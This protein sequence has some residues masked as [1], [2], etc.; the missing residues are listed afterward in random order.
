MKKARLYHLTRDPVTLL[1]G[2]G[3]ICGLGFAL[4]W[5]ITFA[6]WGRKASPLT[7]SPSSYTVSSVED[8][9]TQLERRLTLEQ[10]MPEAVLSEGPE[11]AMEVMMSAKEVRYHIDQQAKDAA[12][13]ALFLAHLDY[14]EKLEDG[15]LLPLTQALAQ[16]P[17]PRFANHLMASV[18]EAKGE[19]TQAML[20]YQAEAAHPEAKR[21]A[22]RAIDLAIQLEDAPVLRQL[23]QSHAATF[24]IL[25]AWDRCA[26]GMLIQDPGLQWEGAAAAVF[27]EVTWGRLLLTTL[28]SA[29]WFLVLMR[30]RDAAD[31]LPWW[32][33]P[34]ALLLGVA[35]IVPTVWFVQF[36][37]IRLGLK[38]GATGMEQLKY[39]VVGVGLREELA[40][41]LL[42]LPFLPW[43]LRK[44]SPGLAL[45]TGALV[46]LGFA[47]EENV[48]YFRQGLASEG[49]GRMLTANFM[50][51]AMTGITALAAYDLCRSK[52]V[53]M[54]DFITV[55]AVIVCV[56]GV[57]DWSFTGLPELSLLGSLDIISI[58]MLALL[59]K[60]F[61]ESVSN[62]LVPQRG[63]ISAICILVW[64]AC[65]MLALAFVSAA[66]LGTGG[67]GIGAVGL[68]ALGYIPLLVMHTRHLQGI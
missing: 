41:L 23:Y 32:W 16:T 24:H 19:W 21:A 38:E 68:G 8:L 31:R 2:A 25:R 53:R 30:Y 60:H 42:V 15:L 34:A 49:Y 51:L 18:M 5:L 14:S 52:F 59:A 37:E 47:F 63:N 62:T 43:L 33:P 45:L 29:I 66:L 6:G 4:A 55:F 7:I 40:K 11:V 46:G 58:V 17:P 9:V 35:S 3:I 57:Y 44:K 22:T 50:H 61:F 20:L 64:G 48:S 12:Q 28:V 65:F 36:Q 26:A 1:R 39:Y 13:K 67:V 10:R 56:H 54:M 27:S